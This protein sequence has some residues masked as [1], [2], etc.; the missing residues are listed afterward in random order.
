[1]ANSDAQAQNSPNRTGN[2]LRQLLLSKSSN[3]S[4]IVIGLMCVILMLLV[5]MPTILLDFF[6]IVNLLVSVFVILTVMYTKD[7]LEFSIFP[8]MLLVSTVFGLA[9][10][11]SS[12][13][14]IL[15]KGINFD[16]QV[17]RAFAS[18]V[19]GGTSTSSILVGIIIFIIIIAVQFMVITKGSTRISEVA[20]R[21]T[22]DA[23]PVKQMAIDAE[24]NAGV[25]TEEQV[26]AKKE[27]LDKTSEFYGSMDGANKFVSGNVKVSIVITLINIIGGL[28][29]GVGINGEPLGMAFATYT[30]LTIGDGLVSQLPALLISVATALVVARVSSDSSFS[31]DVLEQFN[32][33]AKVYWMSAGFLLVLALLPGFPW[34]ILGPFAA[35]LTWRGFRLNRSKTVTE[36]QRIKDEEFSQEKESESTNEEF[37]PVVPIHPISL[38]VGYGL[39]PLVDQENGAELLERITRIRKET[40]LSMGL[41]VPPI[42]IMD[43]IQLEA[44]E[45]SIKIKEQE[46]GMG[47]I[48]MGKY[49]AINSGEVFEEIEGIETVDPAFN[50]PALWVNDE[51]RE[52]AERN[53]YTVVDSPTIIATHLTEAIRN[54]SAEL[55]GRQ[56]VQQILKTLKDDFSVVVE[57]VTKIFNTGEI[58]KVLQSLLNEH[59]SIRNL[60]TILETLADYGE[61]TKNRGFL[62]EKVRQ[63][64]KRQISFQHCDKDKNLSVMTVASSLEQF[65]AESKVET[66]DGDIA[67]FD[68]NQRLQLINSLKKNMQELETQGHFQPVVLCNE[69][70]RPLLQSLTSRD[71]PSLPILSY[72]EISNDV[73]VQSY[74]EISV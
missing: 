14:L 56:E 53:G 35:L 32:Q 43:N 50:L 67:V 1:M 2:F 12:T 59:I 15:I 39:I 13:R 25:L 3:E 38:E 30:S 28:I 16:G 42:R 73:H 55:L 60:V 47:Q 19:V 44:F 64:L 9:L 65:I 8:V 52:Q 68:P 11:V 6:M 4:F 74:A 7:P 41:V 71:L 18:F 63:A 26:K 27:H 36:E 33:E 49:M 70:I 22:L 46:V 24:F 45:Y 37:S 31:Q 54:H 20:A 57:D 40:A 58:Q 66:A 61:M 10:N 62:V 5:P 69:L 17:V 51:Q 72:N 21:F 48:E 23:L 29:V 34:Y